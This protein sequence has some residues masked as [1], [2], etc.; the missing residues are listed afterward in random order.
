M[1]K[2]K[3]FNKR[4]YLFDGDD[5]FDTRGKKRDHGKQSQSGFKGD[6][7]Y[8]RRVRQQSKEYHRSDS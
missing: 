2:D 1:S 8:Q 5:D 3:R 7:S 4:E 6:Y